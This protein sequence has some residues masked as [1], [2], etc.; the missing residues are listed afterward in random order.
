MSS[1]CIV[2]EVIRF[3]PLSEIDIYGPLTQLN[4]TLGRIVIEHRAV[5]FAVDQTKL[6]SSSFSHTGRVDIFL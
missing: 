3:T 5:S 6:F 2:F 1:T 4:V